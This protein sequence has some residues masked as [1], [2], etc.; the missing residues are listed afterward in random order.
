MRVT[1]DTLPNLNWLSDWND[2]DMREKTKLGQ[3]KTLAP[4]RIKPEHADS[5]TCFTISIP[6][7]SCV[8]LISFKKK[9]KEKRT[10]HL[11][12]SLS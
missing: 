11:T 7:I 2:T 3:K 5:F 12:E 6:Y 4:E 8:Y 1:Y 9:K 10:S